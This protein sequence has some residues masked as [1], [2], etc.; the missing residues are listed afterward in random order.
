MTLKRINWPLWS[1]L[2]LS[3]FAFLSYYLIFIWYPT[4]RNFPWA[5]LILFAGALALL[6]AG[7]RR[8]FKSDRPLRSK[9]VAS[10]VTSV[11]VLV[12]AMFLFVFFIAAK[13]IPAAPG[14]PHVGQKA[15]DFTITDTNN[16]PITLAQ[17]L[18]TPIEGKSPKGIV[19]IFY[20][21]YW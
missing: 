1:G 10:I 4:T 15:P 8:A 5:N 7:F 17:L 21:G 16:K 3:L 12:C 6:V 9:I 20:R 19:L 11:G 18:S 2:L 13:W 14:A